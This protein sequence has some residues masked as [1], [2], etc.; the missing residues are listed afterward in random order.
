[1]ASAKTREEERDGDGDGMRTA[2]AG[3]EA[4]VRGWRWQR[5]RQ[6]W[7]TDRRL[8]ARCARTKMMVTRGRLAREA[9]AP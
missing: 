8:W 2:E 1:M 5:A 4:G 9:R 7:E 6:V 3:G